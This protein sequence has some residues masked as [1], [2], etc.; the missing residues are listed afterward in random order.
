MSANIADHVAVIPLPE[1]LSASDLGDYCQHAGIFEPWLDTKLGLV[2]KTSDRVFFE[3]LIA[4]AVK[5]FAD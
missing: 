5:F 4:E 1:G 2:C 3:S